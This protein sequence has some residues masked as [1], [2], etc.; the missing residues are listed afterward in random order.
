MDLLE[1]IRLRRTVHRFLP[2]PVDPGLLRRALEAAI[3]APNHKLTFPWGFV[4]VGP[5]TRSALAD[6][7]VRLKGGDDLPAAQRDA[8]RGTLLGP[9][10]LIVATTPLDPDPLRRLEDYAA[11][12]CGIQNL[13]LVLAAEGVGSKW[14]TG[15]ITR[16][17]EAAA[18]LGLDPT[19][20][21]VA[22]FLWIGHAAPTEAAAPGRPAL[23]QVL[24]ELD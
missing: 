24:R 20:V 1:A 16:T 12:A 6:L 21:E 7:A 10:E 15:A 2:D 8:I 13:S 4:R 19:R 14:G 3:Q 17:P 5:R 9:P 18:I 23:D 11:V 22:G